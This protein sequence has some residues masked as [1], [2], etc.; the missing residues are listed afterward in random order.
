MKKNMKSIREVAEHLGIS[1][2]QIAYAHR[3]LKIPEPLR[4]AGK[5]IYSRADVARIAKHFGI[6]MKEA[7]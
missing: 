5:R 6:E 2:F 7:V 4:V 1:E 3:T